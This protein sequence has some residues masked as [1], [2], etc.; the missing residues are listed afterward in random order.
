[1]TALVAIV[2]GGFNRDL[3]SDV[4]AHIEFVRSPGHI[5][6]LTR[7]LGSAAVNGTAGGGGSV[8][9]GIVGHKPV[10]N[11]QVIEGVDEKSPVEMNVIN[12]RVGRRINVAIGPSRQDPNIKISVT[13]RVSLLKIM[14]ILKNSGQCHGK[15]IIIG[16]H[17]GCFTDSGP[18]RG[19]VAMP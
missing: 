9:S 1:M 6:P 14:I 2:H 8:G 17:N 10:N 3:L 4:L 5:T 16:R 15:T 13:I 12:D 7:V 18:I 19:V 11:N